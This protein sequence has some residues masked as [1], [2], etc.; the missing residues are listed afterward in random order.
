MR[1]SQDKSDDEHSRIVKEVKRNALQLRKD[2]KQF[3]EQLGQ[4]YEEKLNK[5]QEQL[6]EKE[7]EE[8][9]SLVIPKKEEEYDENVQTAFR[10]YMVVITT[11]LTALVLVLLKMYHVI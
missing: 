1:C 4:A 7:E 6:E 2:F 10:I 8:E 11:L 3:K 5:I 9:P